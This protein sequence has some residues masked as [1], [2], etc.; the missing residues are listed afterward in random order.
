MTRGVILKS[1]VPFRVGVGVAV[2]V[3]GVACLGVFVIH[4]TYVAGMTVIIV[5]LR[6]TRRCVNES[7]RRGGV[8]GDAQ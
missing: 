7:W 8:I 2:V 3:V 6:M 4:P 1:V 5:V